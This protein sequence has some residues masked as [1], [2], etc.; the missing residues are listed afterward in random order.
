MDSI[1]SR[2]AN[3]LGVRPQQVAAAVALLD[4]GSTVPFIARY[5][6]EVTGSLDDT[7]L[8]NLEERLRYLR[9]LDE[10]RISILASIEEQGK[11]TPELKRE[12]DLAD[13]KTRLEDLYLPYKQKRRTKGQIALEAGLGELA[14]ALFGN[15]ELNPESEATRFIDAEKGFADVKAVLEGAKYI[16]M[17]RFAEDADLLAKL[18][19][20]L[21]H[22]A[23]LSAR[24]VPGK[25]TEGAKFSDYFEHDEV[26]KNT[27]SHRAL[28]IFRGRNEGI[29][30]VSLKVGDETPGSM[31][32]GEGMIGERFGIA[33]RGR[34]ADKWLAEVVRWTWKVKLYTSLETDLLG[35]LRDK[36]EDEAISVFARNLHDLLLAAPAGPRA[37]LA[38]DPGLRTGCKVAVVDATG[39]LLETATV[40][41]HAPRNDWD[42]TLAILAKLCA[43]HAVDLIAIGNGTASRETDKLA[44]ELIKKVPG[45]KLTKIMVSEAGA[46]VYSAS[47][48]AAREFPDLDVSLRGAVS[49]AR[50]LQDPLAELVKIDPK[51]IGVGQ[52]QHDVS[53]LKLARSLDAVVEDCVNAVGVDVNTASAALLARISGLNAT[54]AQNIVQFRDANGAFKSRSELKKVPRLGEKTFEQAAGFLRVMNGDNPLDASAVHPE[55]YP[56]VQRIAQDTGRDI[57]SLIGDSA[58][59]KR[60]DP[61]QFTD[62]TFGLPTVTD[63]LCELDKPGRDPRP[64]FKTA[65]FQDGVEKLSDLE[66]GMVLEGVVTNVTNFGAFVDIGVHQDGLVHISALSEKF[67]KDP[68]EVVKA[69]DIVKVKVMEVDIPRNRVGL[70]MRMSDTPGAKTDGPQRSGGKPRGNAPRSERHAREDK[71]APANAAMAALFANAKQLRK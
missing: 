56:L 10:R 62:E 54:L 28:A 48:L 15:P 8:R 21:K 44:G 6:K 30:S 43:K 7:Q 27:P 13:T 14:D 2:I 32:P 35:E 31:H 42:G 58:F 51:S 66:P 49:I 40:Y 55:T 5:R 12:I 22:N 71:P 45:L 65:E 34:A 53:Q 67:V 37:T 57:R 63:I 29:L 47:E 33:N 50:R 68:Y 19:D 38:L 69:G 20:F 16:L 39:K 26:L 61:K 17:E 70:S 36:A 24:V 11:L 52:Y 1:N 41:P 9:E 23:T 46:S 25:E 3:E 4:E 59:L 18:R 60:L 64:E